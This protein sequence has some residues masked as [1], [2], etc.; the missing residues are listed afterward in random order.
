MEM[1]EEMLIKA[2]RRNYGIAYAAATRMG[3]YCATCSGTGLQQLV[4]ELRSAYS[5]SKESLLCKSCKGKGV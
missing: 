1:S 3:A 5:R 2:E 4:S